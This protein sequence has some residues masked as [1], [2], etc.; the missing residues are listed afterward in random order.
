MMMTIFFVTIVIFVI[1]SIYLN[2]RTRR[3]YY[4]LYNEAKSLNILDHFQRE[5]EHLR[6][7]YPRAIDAYLLRKAFKHAVIIGKRDGTYKEEI[8]ALLTESKKNVIPLKKWTSNN[9]NKKSP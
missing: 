6:A 8:P 2:W 4:F 3:T 5:I 7:I 9:T 1:A